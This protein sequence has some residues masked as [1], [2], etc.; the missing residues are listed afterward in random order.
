MINK[1]E[2]LITV[3]EENG[4][5]ETER[6]ARES[7]EG[8]KSSK[9]SELASE[10]HPANRL[11]F[12]QEQLKAVEKIKACTNYYQIL[13]VRKGV[14]QDELK[15]QYRKLALQ[16]HP[17]K[18]R[19]PGASEAFKKI[20]SAFDTLR[21]PLRRQH[22]DLFGNTTPL[23]KKNSFSEDFHNNFGDEF[24]NEM[25]YNV[26]CEN[27]NSDDMYTDYGNFWCD[28]DSSRLG[29]SESDCQ[30]PSGTTIAFQ[31]LPVILFVFL[32]ILSSYLMSDPVYS[33][34]RDS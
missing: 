34:S 32:S 10:L 18:N 11:E 7:K 14:D 15:K 29:R 16:Y 19:A 22:Y 33:L 1:V 8:D 17:D 30:R 28:E 23:L 27:Y 2:Q 12:T 13:N 21:D 24:P 6:Q 26:F 3:S 25:F 20:N 31:I 5:Y 9:L 4:R